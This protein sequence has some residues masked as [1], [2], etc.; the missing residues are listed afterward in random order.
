LCIKL[1]KNLL[2]LKYF[3]QR[4]K[5]TVNILPVS[6]KARR[7]WNVSINNRRMLLA[8]DTSKIIG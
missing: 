8:V 7:T 2:Q 1:N 3:L 4:R 6:H 5:L